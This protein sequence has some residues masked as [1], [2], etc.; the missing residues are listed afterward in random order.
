MVSAS[1]LSNSSLFTRGYKFRCYYCN[2]FV[3]T[4]RE[5]MLSHWNQDI[6]CTCPGFQCGLQL[7]CW[8]LFSLHLRNDHHVGGFPEADD[9]FC[10]SCK[11]Y[12]NSKTLFKMHHGGSLFCVRGLKANHSSTEH[13]ETA[14]PHQGCNYKG[15][16]T[17]ATYQHYA[18]THVPRG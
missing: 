1:S 13:L 3:A 18:T 16:C 14:C 11:N 7:P 8:G 6:L 5:D 17:T 15:Q 2:T 12:F 9:K 10:N 4:N